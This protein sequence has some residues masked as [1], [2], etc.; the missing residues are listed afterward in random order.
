MSGPE[1]TTSAPSNS[2]LGELLPVNGPTILENDLDALAA[3]ITSRQGKALDSMA[4]A[5]EVKLD[6]ITARPRFK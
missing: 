4:Y 1:E 3:P 2:R 5:D 6:F